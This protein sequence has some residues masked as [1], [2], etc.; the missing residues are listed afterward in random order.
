MF[1]MFMNVEAGHFEPQHGPH[2]IFSGFYKK[3]M[4]VIRMNVGINTSPEYIMYPKKLGIL[5]PCS[6]AIDLTMKFGPLP[7]YEFAPMKTAPQDMAAS[8]LADMPPPSLKLNPRSLTIL[9][10]FARETKVR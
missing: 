4:N 7:M 5:T 8:T 3:N 6:S 1:F 10:P 9:R 2:L